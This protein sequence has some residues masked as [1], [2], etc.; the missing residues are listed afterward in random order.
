MEERITSYYKKVASVTVTDGGSGYT[1]TSVAVSGTAGQFTCGAT[2]LAINDRV[3]ITGTLGGTGTITGYTLFDSDF[4]KVT[5][6]TKNSQ[7]EL[8]F[9][10]KRKLAEDLIAIIATSLQNKALI[11]S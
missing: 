4:N 10:H 1:L 11:T 8:S 5:V 9:D 3:K 6:L 2:K 7:T